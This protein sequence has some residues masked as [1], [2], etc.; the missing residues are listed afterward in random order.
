MKH[1]LNT[2]PNGKILL[3]TVQPENFVQ[4]FRYDLPMF[5][6]ITILNANILYSDG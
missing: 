1:F 4:L 6:N 2:S 3:D 5:D